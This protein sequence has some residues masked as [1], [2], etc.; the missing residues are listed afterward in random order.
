MG[1]HPELIAKQGVYSE[2]WARQV[3]GDL[4][5][6]MAYLPNLDVITKIVLN[7]S[8]PIPDRSNICY[9]QTAIAG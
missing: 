3:S 6:F 8:L 5:Q 7:P 2:M 4:L 9:N 1:S